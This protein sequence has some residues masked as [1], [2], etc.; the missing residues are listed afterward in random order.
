[1]SRR[2]VVCLV[3]GMVDCLLAWEGRAQLSYA[4]ARAG[5]ERREC[6]YRS[7]REAGVG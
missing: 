3:L 4:L 6:V 5:V 1:M 7:T 2:V